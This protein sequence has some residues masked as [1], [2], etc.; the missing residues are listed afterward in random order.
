MTSN[1]ESP[2]PRDR[3]GTPIGPMG[4]RGP[5]GGGPMGMA[6]PT[7]KAMNFK[8]SLRRLLGELRP[9]RA[10]L[11][12]VVAL[13]TVSVVAVVAAPKVLGRATDVIFR[14]VVGQLLDK[15]MPG[16]TQDQAIAALRQQYRTAT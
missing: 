5:M 11:G 4:G 14:G 1:K 16:L 12:M 9:E 3:P 10:R 2:P 8:D 6:I 7:Q 13:T 15:Q